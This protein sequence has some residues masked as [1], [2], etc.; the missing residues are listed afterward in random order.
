MGFITGE[1]AD[2]RCQEQG[3]WLVLFKTLIGGKMK[4]LKYL[5]SCSSGFKSVIGILV[6]IM[7]GSFFVFEKK[8][9]D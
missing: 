1:I 9:C 3:E 7:T 2:G 4:C 5:S 8:T 6:L